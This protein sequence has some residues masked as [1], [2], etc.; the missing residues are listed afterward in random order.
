[1]SETAT[2]TAGQEK[3]DEKKD[4]KKEKDFPALPKGD[5][6]FPEKVTLKTWNPDGKVFMATKEGISAQRFS[7]KSGDKHFYLKTKDLNGTGKIYPGSEIIDEDG[8]TYTITKVP[9]SSEN[10][11]AV[12]KRKP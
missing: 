3:K 6:P 2:R 7:T 12:V 1:M 4:E 5:L 9:G 10:F 8:I 11:L